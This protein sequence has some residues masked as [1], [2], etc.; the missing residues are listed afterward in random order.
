MNET[1]KVKILI[2]MAYI[3]Y[4]NLES[5]NRSY[6]QSYIEEEMAEYC[7]NKQCGDCSFRVKSVSRC[8]SVFLHNLWCDYREKFPKE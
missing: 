4:N 8:Y 2:T 3:Y 5:I 1:K 6:V 7:Y